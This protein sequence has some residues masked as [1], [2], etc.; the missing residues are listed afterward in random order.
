MKLHATAKLAGIVGIS[1]LAALACSSKADDAPV[2]GGAN[3]GSANGSGTGSTGSGTGSTGVGGGVFVT[4][5]NGSGGIEACEDQTEPA[6]LTPVNLVFMIDVSGS[7]GAQDLNNDGIYDAANEWDNRETRW[8]P[9][10]DALVAFFQNPGATGLQTSLEFFPTG[11]QPT[12]PTAA[13]GDCAAAPT[14]VNTGV[15]NVSTYQYPAVPL[16]SLDVATDVDLLV[17]RIQSVVPAG[18]TP[19]LPALQGAIEYARSSMTDNPGSKSVVVFVT[20][21]LPGVGRST[22]AGTVGEKCF[23]YGQCGC[24]DMDEIPL[25]AQAAQDAATSDPAVLTYVIGMGE[26]DQAAMD[27]IAYAGANQPAFIVQVGD[28]DATKLAFAE[29]LASIRS[30]Q[31]PCEIVMPAPPEGETFD[32]LKVNVAFTPGTGTPVNLAYAGSLAAELGGS[33]L[34]CPAANSATPWFWTYDNEA[35]PTKIILCDSACQATQGD[36]NGAVAVKYG[37]ETNV[38]V[39]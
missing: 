39:F 27:Q 34:T 23:C 31:A 33:Q 32:K 35:A 22:G 12:G 2:G 20:D 37:C 3:G 28:P 10:R 15:C 4:G 29:A 13:D 36:A 38:E 8:N 6:E 5:G 1:L 14:G 21:G 18:G 9:V 16:K 25:V 30:V 26:A 17:S 19:T 24:P 11:G 7:M